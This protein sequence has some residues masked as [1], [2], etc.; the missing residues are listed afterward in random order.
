M[1]YYPVTIAGDT[2]AAGIPVPLNVPD[3]QATGEFYHH[4]NEFDWFQGGS[5]DS[6]G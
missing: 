2:I 6:A 4:Y 3:K 1:V 5:A